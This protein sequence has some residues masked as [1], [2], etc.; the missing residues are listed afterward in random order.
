[1][2]FQRLQNATNPQYTLTTRVEGTCRRQSRGVSDSEGGSSGGAGG[3]SGGPTIGPGAGSGGGVT[4]VGSGIVGAFEWTAISVDPSLPEP[5]DIAVMWLGENGYDVPPGAPTLL[6]PY[7]EEGLY[8][9]ALKLTKGSD[10]GSIRPLVLTYEAS[11]PMIPIK[12]TAVAA[13]EDMGVMTWL[14]G[15]GRGVPQNYLALE[16][17]EARINWFSPNT[18]YNDVVIAAANDAQGQGFVTEFAGASSTLANAVW[19]LPDEY[20]WQQFRGQV[21]QS[22]DDIFLSAN[23]FYGAWDGFWDAV[24]ATVT[25]PAGVAF[26]DFRV[27]PTCYSSQ[28]QF[29]PSAFLGAIE[30]M[31]I[32][33]V[34]LVQD[35]ID[36]HPDVTRLY[37]TLS[38]AEMTTDPLFAYNSDLE[39]VSNIHTAER[40]IE[41]NPNVFEWEASWRIE[42][43][44][45]SVVRGTPDQV[46]TW[47]A[48]FSDQP[49]N[50]RILRQAESGEGREVENNEDDINAALNAYNARI[51]RAGSSGGDSDSGCN[52]AQPTTSRAAWIGLG[53]ALFAFG[54]RRRRRAR[55]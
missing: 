37:S 5:A 49:A 39:D 1:M 14:L 51:P 11:R 42:L 13:N 12:L 43:P 38:A 16:L 45:G 10:V 55:V 41:C 19:T 31:V 40:I 32:E 23:N 47:P 3:S 30:E 53:L 17:N 4:V 28:I 52:I 25:L 9:L 26:E 33:P 54:G 15:T 21:Y 7:L 35:L 20:M 34:R 6:G 22:F 18:N 24:R 44:Q 2:A 29:S 36:A 46:G 48:E 50:F 8:L 27:C